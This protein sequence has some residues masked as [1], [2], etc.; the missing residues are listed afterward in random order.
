MIKV[1]TDRSKI[2]LNKFLTKHDIYFGYK[3]SNKEL[4]ARD[5]EII[6]N[7]DGAVLTAE[8]NIHGKYGYA[9]LTDISAG[10]KVVLNIKHMIEH[11]EECMAVITS[12]GDNA[13]TELITEIKPYENE[14][15]TVIT[16]YTPVTTSINIYP[17]KLYVNDE[18]IADS[19]S[20]VGHKK[21]E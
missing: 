20:G 6:Y 13:L 17:V 3:T 7:I 4:D 16:L 21:G 1:Y 9:D 10:A 19:F 14:K 12:C 2:D 5:K 8:G 11:G 15:D 18:Y